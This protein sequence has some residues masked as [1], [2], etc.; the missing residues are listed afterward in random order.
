MPID[1]G[2]SHGTGEPI[3]RSRVDA[4]GRESLS[5]LA[6][7]TQLLGLAATYQELPAVVQVNTTVP[8]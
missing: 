1:I 2:G 7:P 6:L 4:V 8:R 5:D 3:P